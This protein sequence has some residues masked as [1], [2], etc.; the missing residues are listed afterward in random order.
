MALKERRD[1]L[2]H[3]DTID[4]SAPNVDDAAHPGSAATLR[5]INVGHFALK[6]PSETHDRSDPVVEPNTK[7]REN[8]AP[9]VMAEIVNQELVLQAPPVKNDR[10]APVIE[11]FPTGVTTRTPAPKQVVMELKEKSE[12]IA[13][14]AERQRELIAATKEVKRP[15]LVEEIKQWKPFIAEQAEHTRQHSVP[16]MQKNVHPHLVEELKARRPSIEE[17]SAYAA[18]QHMAENFRS[19]VNP[20]LVNEIKVKQ[21]TVDTLTRLPPSLHRGSSTEITAGGD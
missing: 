5:T 21:P 18:R 11:R 3:V 14:N 10:S 19:A 13:E 8:P 15:E 7:L 1:S 4:R 16:E 2:T 20:S 17:F 9:A 12:L 6:P